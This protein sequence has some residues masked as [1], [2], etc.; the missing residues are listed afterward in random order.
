MSERRRAVAMIAA[1]LGLGVVIGIAAGLLTLML[2]GI[3]H[4]ALGF[5]ESPGQPGPFGTPSWR[6]ALS[7]IVGAT[8]AAVIW[9]LLRT[10]SAKVPSVTKAVAGERMPWWQTIVHVLLQILIVGCGMSIGREVAPREFGALAGQRASGWLKL[11]AADT[12][13]IVAVAAGAGLAGVYNAPLAGAFFAVEILLADVTLRTVA[14]AFACSTVAAWVGTLIKGTHTFYDMGEPSGLFTPDLMGFAL[15]AGLVC[16]VAGAV[17]RFGSSWAERHHATGNAILWQLPLAGVITGVVAIWVPQVM[18]NGRA[19]A[20]MGFGGDCDWALIGV[21]LVSCAVKGVMTLLTIR[22]GAS[23][24]V[25][26]PGIAL[27]ATLGAVLGILWMQGFG[28]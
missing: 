20:Q 2:Y 11:N 23:G 9:W 25:L 22:S 28:T 14:Y 3:E 7:V 27:G 17:F 4:V 26:T 16:G 5:V 6:R 1:V 15:V 21:L 8:L 18:G 10:R 19:T 24:G 12:R 13:T